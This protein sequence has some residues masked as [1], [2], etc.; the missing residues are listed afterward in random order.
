MRE[1]LFF[2]LGSLTWLGCHLALSFLSVAICEVSILS[3]SG[4]N[5]AASDRLWCVLS[6][7]G[8]IVAL[9]SRFAM[10]GTRSYLG[11]KIEFLLVKST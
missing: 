5:H 3:S 6:D 2:A 8:G 7:D 10:T 1:Y 9:L 4:R 11:H